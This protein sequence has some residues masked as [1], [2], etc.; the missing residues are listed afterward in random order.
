MDRPSLPAEI[1]CYIMSFL[2]PTDILTYIQLNRFFRTLINNSSPIQ[3]SLELAKYRMVSLL[4]SHDDPSFATRLRLIRQRERSWRS[5]QSTPQPL[6]TLTTPPTGSV[7]E[8]NTC[9]ANNWETNKVTAGI[10]FYELPSAS[11]QE[12]ATSA[13]LKT[14]TDPIG[15]SLKMQDFTMDVEQDLL[16][17]VVLAPSRPSFGA[18]FLQTCPNTKPSLWCALARMAGIED[19]TFLVEDTFLIARPSGTFECCTFE[20]P[21]SQSTIPTLR[22]SYALPPLADGYMYW[23]VPLVFDLGVPLIKTR[24]I[25]MSS[26]PAPGYLPRRSG[27]HRLYYP[28]PKDRVHACCLYIFKPNGEDRHIH[29]FIFFICVKAFL[30]PPPPTPRDFDHGAVPLNTL[31]LH[32][33]LRYLNPSQAQARALPALRSLFNLSS[34]NITRSIPWDE[35]GLQNTRCF[36]EQLSTDWQHTLYGQRTVECIKSLQRPHVGAHG[37][38]SSLNLSAA[39]HYTTKQFSTFANLAAVRLDFGHH[40][41]GDPSVKSILSMLP[42]HLTHLGP[43]ELDHVTTSLLECVEVSMIEVEQAE[44]FI[45]YAA[46]QENIYRDFAACAET[47]CTAPRLGKGKRW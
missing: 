35:W 8:F 19:F 34:T 33:Q 40:S 10:T 39:A 17:L 30:E 41:D 11:V 7:Y 46:K 42:I 37:E 44:G 32:L 6:T 18:A 27:S 3:M 5:P 31:F 2:P 23:C 16:V 22:M 21:T 36:D 1:L 9:Y 25:C 47:T 26:N 38:P 24:Y 43:T 13:P 15:G 45:A 28:R 4:S 29:S 12:T 20:N 14:W